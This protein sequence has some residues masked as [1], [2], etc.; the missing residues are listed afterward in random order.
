MCDLNDQRVEYSRLPNQSSIYSRSILSYVVNTKPFV[1]TI[2]IEKQNQILRYLRI[3]KSVYSVKNEC[4][5]NL[6]LMQLLH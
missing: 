4:I 2:G 1:Q 6:R 3:G 5:N